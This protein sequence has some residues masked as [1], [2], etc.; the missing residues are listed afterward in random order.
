M[1]DLRLGL[2]FEFSILGL[3]VHVGSTR[4]LVEK[5]K[6]LVVASRALLNWVEFGNVE[7]AR[8]FGP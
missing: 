7:E 1:L 4:S 5:T 2:L 6:T 3:R 8:G